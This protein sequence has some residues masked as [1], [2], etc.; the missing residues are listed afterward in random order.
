LRRQV[1]GGGQCHPDY[2]GL[3]RTVGDLPYG[4]LVCG[5]RGGAD[6]DS[7]LA[8]LV[9]LVAGHAGRAQ[10]ED[11]ERRAQKD[12]DDIHEHVLAKRVAGLAERA[13]AGLA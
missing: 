8:G 1:A 11:V 6:D 7:A 2:A 5:D 3:S 9:R 4:A 10:A 12:V 13:A